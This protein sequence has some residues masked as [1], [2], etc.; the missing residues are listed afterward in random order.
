[1]Q[2]LTQGLIKLWKQ[3]VS[4]KLEPLLSAVWFGGITVAILSLWGFVQI[5]D[6]VLEQ[7]TQ[8]ID[9]AILQAIKLTH[10]PWLDQV[11]I[12][13]TF[14]G[15]PL[16]LMILSVGFSIILLLQRKWFS[17]VTLSI[18]TAGGVELNFLLKDLF[19]R[20]RPDLWD[21]ILDVR[22]YSFPSGHAMI[23]LIVYG[24]I[25]YWIS[26]HHRRWRNLVISIVTVL[27]LAIGISRLYLGVHWPTDI[28]AGY[29]AGVVWLVTCISSLE[30]ASKIYNKSSSY[31]E[32][33]I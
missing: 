28:V 24:F 4:T 29:A 10:S 8:A 3:H 2:N 14:L 27:I 16:V 20:T 7:E 31:S 6:G 26:T 12:G 22:Q 15:E 19:A 23:S 17:V 32:Q 11:M 1:M 5:A 30:I 33:E 21:R 13:I 18:L 25:G 9:T